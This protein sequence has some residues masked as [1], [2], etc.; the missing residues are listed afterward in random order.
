MPNTHA[1]PVLPLQPL[2]KLSSVTG[3]EQHVL[4]ELMDSTAGWDASGRNRAPGGMS[5]FL[6][7]D[8]EMGSTYPSPVPILGKKH[9]LFFWLYNLSV[10]PH[11]F[12]KEKTY[13]WMDVVLFLKF[14]FVSL[15]PLFP[16]QKEHFPHLIKD[17]KHGRT[18]FSNNTLGYNPRIL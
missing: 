13:G 8:T 16:F 1:E 18:L 14:A 6:S 10:L 2:L 9:I 17:W 3:K 11:T 7:I 5:K 12:K 4:P 15:I